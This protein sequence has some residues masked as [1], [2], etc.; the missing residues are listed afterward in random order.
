MTFFDRKGLIIGETTSPDTVQ[1]EEPNQFDDENRDHESQT[2]EPHPDGLDYPTHNHEF[3]LDE[4][5]Y[6][7]Q[8]H[9][10]EPEQEQFDPD[11]TGFDVETPDLHR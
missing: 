7:S 5:D 9:G 4:G 6:D 3:G 10:S 2:E 8:E 1:T 11:P